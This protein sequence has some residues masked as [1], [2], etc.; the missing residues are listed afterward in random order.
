MVESVAEEPG[1][2]GRQPALPSAA[3]YC[4]TDSQHFLGAVALLNSLRIQG[5]SEPLF[6]LDCGLEP[7]ERALLDDHATLVDA[8]PADSP[9][10]L[11]WVAPLACPA[12]AMLLL[13]ADMIVTRSLVPLLDD[14]VSGRVVVVADA[15]PDRFDER[16]ASLLGLDGVRRQTYVNS[17]LIG[18]PVG[19]GTLLFERLR[20]FADVVDIDRSMFR[21][22]EPSDPFFFADQDILNALLGSEFAPHEVRVL[23]HRLAPH[24]PFPGV[25]LTDPLLLRCR[26][27]DG[28]EPFVL[29]HAHQKPWLAR[30]PLCVYSRLLPRLW[31]GD[32]VAV[33]VP[34]EWV[35]VALRNGVLSR[36]AR[37][38]NAGRFVVTQTRRRLGIQPRR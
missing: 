2:A 36:I 21:N 30:G 32:D 10:M 14:S 37:R 25:E 16:W 34:E 29:H 6:V 13:D 5:H 12:E 35:P 20:D 17:G 1:A 4:V 19:L 9:A 31:F 7:E 24:S 22:G 28:E 23:D 33:S 8:P 3:F 38:W 15:L 11:K 26:Y 27:D 18:A